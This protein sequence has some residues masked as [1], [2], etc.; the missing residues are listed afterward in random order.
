MPARPPRR[1]SQHDAGPVIV[2]ERISPTAVRAAAPKTTVRQTLD[3]PTDTYR[4]VQADA[5]YYAEQFGLPARDLSAQHV[6]R[7][8][9]EY[10][11][12][13]EAR[14]SEVVNIA[15]RAADARAAERSAGA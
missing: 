4:R 13:D 14:I 1:R 10:V 15:R 9:I 5:R 2:D 6:L 3:L 12:A 11:Y 8:M 7:A